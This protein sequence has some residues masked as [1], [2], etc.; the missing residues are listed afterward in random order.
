MLDATYVQVDPAAVA[1]PSFSSL[2]ASAEFAKAGDTV[3]FELAYQ[4]AIQFVHFT[5]SVPPTLTLS[6]GAVATFVGP[7]AD[8]AGT[9][10][11]LRVIQQ[12]VQ[13]KPPGDGRTP[14]PEQAAGE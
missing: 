11:R 7:A 4:G 10:P 2:T 13:P 12:C 6:N 1:A 9:D 3:T 8:G 14:W 5:D